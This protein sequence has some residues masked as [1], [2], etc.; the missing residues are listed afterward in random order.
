[1]IVWALNF[2]RSKKS[3][4]VLELSRQSENRTLSLFTAVY[5][6]MSQLSRQPIAELYKSIRSHFLSMVS[7]NDDDL[8]NSV[9]KFFIEL[10][11]V[12]YLH[13]INSEQ[14]IKQ[15]KVFDFHNDY[16]HCLTRMYDQ[17]QPFGSI[18]KMLSKSIVQSVQMGSVF[19][20]AL[21]GGAD[22][23]SNVESLSATNLDK[24]CKEALVKMSYC[25]SC[26][27]YSHVKPCYGYCMNVMRGCLYLYLGSLNKDWNSFTDDIPKLNSV[28]TSQENGIETVIRS[29]DTKLSEAIMYAM[30]NG[31]RIDEKVKHACG[32]PNLLEKV[33]DGHSHNLQNI[34]QTVNNQNSNWPSPIHT[35]LVDF[36]SSVDRSKDFFMRISDSLCEDYQTSPNNYQKCWEGTHLGDYDHE[37]IGFDQQKYNPA[38]IIPQ[39]HEFDTNGNSQLHILNDKLIN[40]RNI[41]LKPLHTNF[42]T[43]HDNDK[44][45]SDMAVEDGSGGYSEE[46]NNDDEDYGEGSGF[47]A[48]GD[49]GIDARTPIVGIPSDNNTAET[50]SG[51][52]VVCQLS[53]VS[54]LSIL[55][56]GMIVTQQ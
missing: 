20:K 18:P 24:N 9:Y 47:A 38:V 13:G 37:I 19:L 17:F 35:V 15:T 29:L 6:R 46:T 51:S 5:S 26:K 41:V 33:I 44:M 32:N 53:I 34:R 50:G 1:M 36:M 48:S 4:H 11:P 10:F 12:A 55:F 22:V 8:E 23:L 54:Y 21:T 43:K 40:L 3:F 16:K 39:T 42:L 27:G 14:A 28:V 2:N 7:N 31:P 52:N 45:F 30:E 49:G 56:V 25:S